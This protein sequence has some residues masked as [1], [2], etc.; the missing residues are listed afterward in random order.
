[1]KVSGNKPQQVEK[2]KY[3]GVVFMRDGM[4]SKEIDTWL[5]KLSSLETSAIFFKANSGVFVRNLKS[6]NYCKSWNFCEYV[7]FLFICNCPL[8]SLTCISIKHTLTL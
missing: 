7:C 5:D 2:F 8:T 1:M 4:R 6:V 3:L